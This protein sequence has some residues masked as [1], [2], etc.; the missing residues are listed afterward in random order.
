MKTFLL[1]VGAQKAGT[2]WL[3]EY[4]AQNS[5]VNFGRLKEYHIWDAIYLNECSNFAAEKDDYLRYSLQRL[6]GAYEKY[7]SSL[8]TGGISLTGDITPS[9]SGL[10]VEA[11]KLLRKKLESEGFD[12]KVVF[13]MRDPF[14][15][16]WSAVRMGLR[17]KVLE[18]T[19]MD[20]LRSL[21]KSAGYIFRT[22]YVYTIKNLEL[23]FEDKQIY[24]GIYE[25]IFELDALKSISD[26]VGVHYDPDFVKKYFNISPKSNT[27]ELELKKEIVNFY[28][29][30][31][32]FC[33]E[34]FPQTK[35]LWNSLNE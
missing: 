26:F 1:C 21:Y 19:E 25:E 29:N 11:F 32:Q 20:L 8:I 18:G 28:S 15:R 24:Y 13:L 6:S 33:F 31:Y 35:M 3:Y 16:C 2:T 7:F 23:V 34:R 27:P 12:V 5:H 10:P 17:T 4:L 30:V 9:Y 14:E 22:N